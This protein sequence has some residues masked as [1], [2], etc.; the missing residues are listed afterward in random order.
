MTATSNCDTVPDLASFFFN[1]LVARLSKK[2]MAIA[3]S[4]EN[5]QKAPAVKQTIITTFI[6]RKS[7]V[8][9][10]ITQTL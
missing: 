6:L 8:L 10:V 2:A 9:K 5:T 1:I 3:Q 7:V 4:N